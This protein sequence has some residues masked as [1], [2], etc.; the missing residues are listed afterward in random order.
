MKPVIMVKAIARISAS[1]LL[2][3]LLL[4]CVSFRVQAADLTVELPSVIE[5]RGGAF[6]LGE[7]ADITGDGHIAE[8]ASMAVISPS[9]GEFT[10]DDVVA[11][12]GATEAAGAAVSIRMPD[13]VKVLPEQSVA[14]ELRAMTSWKWRIDVDGADNLAAGAFSLPPN[15]LPGVKSLSVKLLKPDGDKA[16]KQVKLRWYQPVVYSTSA[17]GKDATLTPSTLRHRI[18]AAGMSRP[19]VWDA[20]QL[21]DATLRR[22]VRA[23]DAIAQSDVESTLIVRSGAS[24]RLVASVGGLGV[25]VRGIALQRGGKGDIIKVR[26]LSTRKIL[27]G[28]VIDAGR[29]SIIY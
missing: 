13:A 29:V 24:V 19:L 17:L 23:G 16:N 7:Y 15:V 27:S 5:V 10:V 25:E 28:T 2:A 14:A 4:M 9:G 6:Y 8:S 1:A 22:G 18:G 21:A 20:N 11:A 12:L 3:S 26:N